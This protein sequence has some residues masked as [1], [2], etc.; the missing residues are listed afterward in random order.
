LCTGRGGFRSLEWKILTQEGTFGTLI[1]T[2]TNIGENTSFGR[3]E[4]L[5][6][7][8]TIS[9]AEVRRRGSSNFNRVDRVCLSEFYDVGH[10]ACIFSHEQH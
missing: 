5:N 2:N 8:T 10:P 1:A 3:P 6:S 7:Y 9:L 4:N